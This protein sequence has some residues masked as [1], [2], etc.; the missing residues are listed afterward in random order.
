MNGAEILLGA[1]CRPVAPRLL[2]LDEQRQRA[3]DAH[4]KHVERRKQLHQLLK[5]A[6]A[7]ED[8]LQHQIVP[9]SRIGRQRAVKSVEERR[10]RR[11]PVEFARLEPRH[12]QHARVAQVIDGNMPERLADARLNPA[13]QRR[14]AAARCTMQEDDLDRLHHG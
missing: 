14:L 4:K 1:A 8:M 2:A 13:R 3:M 12:W 6:L 5:P 11:L 7:I 9:S 10:P